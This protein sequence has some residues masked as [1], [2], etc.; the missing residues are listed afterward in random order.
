MNFIRTSDP[1]F[2]AFTLLIGA[3]SAMTPACGSETISTGPGSSRTGSYGSSGGSSTVNGSSGGLDAPASTGGANTQ[4]ETGGSGVLSETGGSPVVSSTGGSSAQAETGGSPVASSTGGAANVGGATSVANAGTGGAIVAI[5][6]GGSASVCTSNS[7]WRSGENQ[8]MRPG[9]ACINCHSYSSEAPAFV[10]AGTVYPTVREPADCNG[11]NSSGNATVI[12]T[13]AN[14]T[15]HSVAVNSVGNFMLQGAGIP[16]PYHAKV[17]VGTATRSMIAA[18]TSGD[19]N[20][21]HTE[22]GANG[23]PGRIMLP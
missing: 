10:V 8:S 1:R 3:I 9:E 16:L 4:L 7:F 14:G 19:C 11:S 13:D 23:A 17:Q 12:I 15:A 6:T 22:Q 20:S 18:Q 5:A 21:C 2:L